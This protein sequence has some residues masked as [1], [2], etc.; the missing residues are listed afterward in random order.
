M[1]G[2]SR[3]G[4]DVGTNAFPSMTTQENRQLSGGLE[5]IETDG[6]TITEQSSN[7]DQSGPLAMFVV[8][9]G[10]QFNDTQNSDEQ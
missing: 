10:M 1:T 8:E 6:A 5:L 7:R 4:A 3:P 2:G 9:G